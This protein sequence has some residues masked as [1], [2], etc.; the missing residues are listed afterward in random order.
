MSA[1]TDVFKK[2]LRE[3][4]PDPV[5]ALYWLLTDN[6]ALG[7]RAPLDCVSTPEGRAE[8]LDVLGRIEQGIW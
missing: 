8:V 6:H 5:V 4:I 7:G 3:V 1:E 2:R